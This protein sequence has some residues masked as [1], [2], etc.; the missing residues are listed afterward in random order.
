ML[1]TEP[2]PAVDWSVT[3]R[4]AAELTPAAFPNVSELSGVTY[5]GPAAGGLS[6][7]MAIQDSGGGLTTF[8]V[9]FSNDGSLNALAPVSDLTLAD[10][11]LDF[12]GVAYTGSASNSVFAAYEGNTNPADTIPGVAEYSLVDGSRVS[13][14]VLPAAWT[15]NGNAVSNYGFESLTL[16]GDGSKL[17]TANEEGLTID[18]PLASATNGTIV[19]LQELNRS[20]GAVTAGAQYAYEVDPWHAGG[21]TPADRSGLVDLVSLPDGTLLALERSLAF[22]IPSFDSRIYQ[23]DFAGATDV[24]QSPFDGGLIGRSY[25]A[26][27]KTLLWSGA[28]L[29]VGIFGENL[30]G[31]ALGPRLPSGDWT[32][33]GVTDSGTALD[34]IVSFE[35]TPDCS[36]SGDYNCSG[37]VGLNDL[38]LLLFNWNVDGSMVPGTWLHESP[39]A[40]T[41]VGLSQ[42]NGVL[43][44][45]GNTVSVATV[46]EPHTR[47][48]FLYVLLALRVRYGNFL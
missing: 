45:W 43:F 17:W 3:P 22:S 26:V 36:L 18:G 37:Q 20:G 1:S 29:P 44:N 6:R 35:L 13:T 34:Y 7:F 8:D 39:P 15:T 32:L 30:E 28:V 10:S 23:I 24:S 12:E 48:V 5:Q 4:S 33:L 11:T 2:A 31:L 41:L 27:S 25:T 46:P 40:G 9:G 47:V 21:G 16:T 19:R 42:L 14:V 38:N